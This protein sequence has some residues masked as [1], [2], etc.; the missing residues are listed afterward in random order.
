MANRRSRRLT[1]EGEPSQKT[2][3]GL[4]NPIPK[5]EEFFGL[6]KRAVRK[7]GFG[8]QD[9]STRVVTEVTA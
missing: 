5:A 6:L 9:I 8:G 2:D 4:E 1:R 7:A 3:K